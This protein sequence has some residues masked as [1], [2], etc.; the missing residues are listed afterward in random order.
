MLPSPARVFTLMLIQTPEFIAE[1]STVNNLLLPAHGIGRN[2]YSKINAL[3][4]LEHWA[5]V[6]KEHMLH[7][8]HTHPGAALLPGT[9]LRITPY[10]FIISI[11]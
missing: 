2:A 7:E 1:R 5:T 4:A 11:H 3:Q 8:A 6:H 10:L 9:S